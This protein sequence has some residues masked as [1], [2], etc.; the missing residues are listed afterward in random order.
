M[1]NETL[2]YNYRA[3]VRHWI[4]GDTVV[5]DIDL[6]FGTWI[7]GEHVRLL[8]INTPEM[9]PQWKTF[10]LEGE[11]YEIDEPESPAAI[12]RNKVI[13]KAVAARDYCTTEA[14][15]GS[16]VLIK[17]TLNKGKYGR[18]LALVYTQPELIAPLNERISINRKL[19]LVGHAEVVKY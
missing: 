10:V 13:A 3:M 14:P 8:G 9:K 5:L 4:D 11:S 1:K 7:R 12:A 19:V 17:T 18:T 15:S 6:G 16:M 2:L